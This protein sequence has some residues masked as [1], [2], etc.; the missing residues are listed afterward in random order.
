MQKKVVSRIAG[1]LCLIVIGVHL[2]CV[3]G[4]HNEFNFIIL[5]TFVLLLK[6]TF[7]FL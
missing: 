6:E 4:C 2:C 1:L 3:S 7:I 5:N